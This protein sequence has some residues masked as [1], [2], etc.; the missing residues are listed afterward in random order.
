MIKYRSSVEAWT[1]S[2]SS[3]S[4]S[5]FFDIMRL[6]LGEIETPYNKSRLIE[7]L[8]AFIKNQT[9]STNMIA[10][11][12]EY[13]VKLLTAIAFIPNATQDNLVDFFAAEYNA[14]D[15]FWGLSNLIERLFIFEESDKYQNKKYLRLN[16]LLYDKLEELLDL[17]NIVIPAQLAKASIDDVFTISPDFI[18]AFI[19]FIN[20]KS[21]SCKS[22]GI[23]K[24][25]VL[26]KVQQIF[27]GREKTIQLL[28]TAFIN[29]NLIHEGEK[30]YFLDRERFVLFANIP[31]A[32]QYALLCAASCSRFS[33]EGLKKEAQLLLD[34][35]C[36]IPEEGAKLADI[37]KLGFLAASSS[38][39][40]GS[41]TSRFSR[42]LEAARQD[43]E[44]V[45]EQAASLIDR[46]LDS[47][48]NFGLIS[49]TGYDSEG[50]EI[51][52][53]AQ[54]MKKLPAA[55]GQ[56]AHKALNIDSAFTVSI[57]PG[58]SLKELLPLMDFL[59]IKSCALVSEY[60]ITRQSVSVAFDLGWEVERLCGELEKYTPYKLPQNLR[61]S[62]LEWY[63]SYTSAMLYHGYILKVAKSNITMVE[64]NPRIRNYIK[65][66]LAEGIYLLNI[67]FEADIAYFEE[68]SG[69][70]FMGR[71]KNPL[72]S[73][74][75]LPF[76]VLREGLC[77]GP[78]DS[79]KKGG[80]KVDFSSAKKLLTALKTELKNMEV[81][82][83]QRESLEN[84]IGHRLI[85]TKAH[86]LQTSV[87]SEILEADGMDFGGKLHLFE[88]GLKENDM[89]EITLPSFDD[90]S[91]YFKVIGRT[92]GIT[93]QT[94]DAIV[95]FEVYPGGEITN[96][97]VSR[98]TYL[99]RL[100]F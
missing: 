70:D 58:L 97:V 41:S 42:M 71:V 62:I 9:N 25:N 49:K 43:T 34:A 10:L 82:K 69:L 15:I 24:K 96:F 94:G 30:A 35:L 81:T 54:I 18:A 66:K 72:P 32:Q 2:I 50:H 87:R 27:P 75:K 21:C 20:T 63:E 73:G 74:D 92:L 38:P 7:R 5:R 80:K 53:C 23:L 13:D 67:P 86:L 3:L 31:A 22:D 93:K 47:A 19:S 26:N 77:I 11:L 90:E 84:R 55:M 83:N 37:I 39:S 100:R 85:L 56:N 17:S 14:A 28:F 57:M 45:P 79:A 98:I 33:R 44:M 4:D 40:Q 89:M 36:S 8:A 65:E 6:Y 1:S 29:L 48:V 61:I 68:E 78:S 52:I 91:K 88:A 16:P 59:E 12:D 46:M 64:N 51:Y 76:P 99:R 60:E 95:R